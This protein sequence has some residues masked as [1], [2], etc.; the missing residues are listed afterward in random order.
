MGKMRNAHRILVGKL[1]W[2][3]PHVRLRHAR[4]N[5]IKIDLIHGV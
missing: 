3:R 2:K 5:N 1:E 4:E